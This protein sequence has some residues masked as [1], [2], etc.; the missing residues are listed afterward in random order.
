[1]RASILDGATTVNGVA[2]NDWENNIRYGVTLSVPVTRN[3]SAKLAASTGLIVRA[4]GNY[5]AI[6]RLRSHLC[7]A[8]TTNSPM[9]ARRFCEATPVQVFRHGFP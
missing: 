7:Q 5:K 6:F 9:F 4:G 3:W 1:M 8:K 2:N